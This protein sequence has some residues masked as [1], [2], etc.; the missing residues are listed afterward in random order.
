MTAGR[1]RPNP[2]RT[3][4]PR[5]PPRARYRS[6]SPRTEEQTFDVDVT[7]IVTAWAPAAAGGSG[8]GQYGFG[9]FPNG[10]SD[11]TRT[12]E[13]YSAKAGSK[14]PQLL[15]TVSTNRPPNAPA[16]VSPVG[17]NTAIGA[18]FTATATDPDGQDLVAWNVELTDDQGVAVWS[19]TAGTGIAGSTIVAA[20]G[21][22][23]LTLGGAYQWRMRVQDSAGGWSALSLW[24]WFTFGTAPPDPI[25]RWASAILAALARPRPLTV[26]GT[27]RPRDALVAAVLGAEYGDRLEVVDIHVSPQID[28]LVRV[29]GMSADLAPGGISVSIVSEDVA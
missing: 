5:R 24:T 21:G 16:P 3:P 28:R 6:G 17:P 2:R 8:A 10:E 13:L 12:T 18:G 26:L 19:A 1:F 7:A 29:L 9:L 27:I 25:T 15:I 14:A 22:P 23:A 11:G 20:Y 4:A